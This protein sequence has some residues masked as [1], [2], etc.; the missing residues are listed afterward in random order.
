M[1]FD[2]KFQSKNGF[3][4][5]AENFRMQIDTGCLALIKEK[6]MKVSILH[7]KLIHSG[8]EKVRALLK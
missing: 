3:M 5:G 2:T 7:G 6:K 4:L 1:A 8:E